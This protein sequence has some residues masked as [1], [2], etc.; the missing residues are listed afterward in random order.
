MK[1]L[2]VRIFPTEEQEKIIWRHIGACR[3]IWNW[4]LENQIKEYRLTRHRIGYTKICKELT[5]LKA[6]E[7]FNWLNEISITSLQQTLRELDRA[8]NDYFTNDKGFPKFKRKKNIKKSYPVESRKFYFDGEYIQIAKLGRVKFYSSY[9][10]NIPNGNHMC[11][12]YN[13]RIHYRNNKWILT[14]AVDDNICDTQAKK[15]KLHEYSVG[16]DLGIK[17]L[18]SV[19]VD[20]K[21]I[22]IPNINKSHKVKLLENKLKHLKKV[23]SRKYNQNGRTF[24]KTNNIIR[25]ENQIRKIYYHLKN[26]RKDYIHQTT[27]LITNLYPKSIIMEDLNVAGLIKNKHLTKSI[28]D[29]CFYEFKRQIEYKSKDRGVEFILADRFYPSS[30]TCSNC[31]NIKKDL[32]LSDRTYICS[33]CGLVIDRDY[34]AAINLMRYSKH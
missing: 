3:F 11:R 27:T 26:I 23:Q 29:Q 4:S 7:E 25:V 30:K 16:I 15:Q 13:A 9:K 18:C 32:K 34:N 17:V 8:Y 31:G 10:F 14:F 1:T 22:T 21:N 6:T 2:T 33:E 12:F 20:D 24:E 28:Q 5:K 19:A